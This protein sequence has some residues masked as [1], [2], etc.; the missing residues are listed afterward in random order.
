M[1]YLTA[2]NNQLLDFS[3]E[4]C[5]M[6]PSDTDIKWS[7]NVISVVKKT[8]PRKLYEVFIKFFTNYRSKILAREES[9]FT[10]H[11]F[12]EIGNETNKQEYTQTIVKQLRS[13]WSSMSQNSRNMCWLRFE[14]LFKISD[15]IIEASQASNNVGLAGNC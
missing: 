3:K 15:K 12:S 9:F 11:S 7:Y 14:V 13:H 4:L 6:F 2:F 8:H 1:S 5:E 10:T